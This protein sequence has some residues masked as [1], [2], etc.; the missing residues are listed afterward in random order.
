MKRRTIRNILIFV[1]GAAAAASAAQA[2]WWD[3]Y[4]YGK[5][6]QGCVSQVCGS[7]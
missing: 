1:F 4:W 3:D 5:G 6:W 7:A 2:N